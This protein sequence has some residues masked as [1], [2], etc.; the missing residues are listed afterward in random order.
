M[1]AY[2]PS[3]RITAQEALNDIWIQKNASSNAL[4]ANVLKK[5]TGFYVL[6]LIFLITEK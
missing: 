5:L 6:N 2:N 4:N 3:Q 1:L